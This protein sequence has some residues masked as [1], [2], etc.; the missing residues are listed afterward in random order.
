M[1]DSEIVSFLNNPGAE[2]FFQVDLCRRCSKNGFGPCGLPIARAGGPRGLA[3]SLE[4]GRT[5]MLKTPE[6]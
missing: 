3:Q 1:T 5:G 4:G 6:F 2:R